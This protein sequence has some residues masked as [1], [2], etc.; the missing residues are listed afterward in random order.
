MTAHRSAQT[1]YLLA[2]SARGCGDGC[3][4]LPVD[5]LSLNIFQSSKKFQ[6]T[7]TGLATVIASD[8]Q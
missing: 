4:L 1:H 3:L 5:E 2:S 7:A 8:I 6:L